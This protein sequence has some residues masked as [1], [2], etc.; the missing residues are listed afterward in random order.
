MA[1]E[2]GM[3]TDFYHQ[4]VYQPE[5]YSRECLDQALATIARLDKPVVAY[6]V[7]AAGRVLPD[8]AF[9]SLLQRLKPKD[10]LC[11]GVFPKDDPDQVAENTSLVRRLSERA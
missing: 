2:R 10:G 4:C 7:L 3:P 6:K 5:N 11:V 8:T 9:V 1:E